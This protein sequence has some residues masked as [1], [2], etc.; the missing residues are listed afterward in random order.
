[1]E[2]S[3]FLV[4]QE[5]EILPVVG[6]YIYDSTVKPHRF[7]RFYAIDYGFNISKDEETRTENQP[8]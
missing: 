8:V 7:T 5:E 6:E 2:G 4:L 1:M 3:D